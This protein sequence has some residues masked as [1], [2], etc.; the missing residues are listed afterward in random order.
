MR[1][2]RKIVLSI[3]NV[4]STHHVDPK[5]WKPSRPRGV[6][7]VIGI[8]YRRQRFC[9]PSLLLRVIGFHCSQRPIADVASKFSLSIDCLDAKSPICASWRW[10]INSWPRSYLR[11]SF[12]IL[13]PARKV[14]HIMNYPLG[15][16]LYARTIIIHKSL[17]VR[18]QLQELWSFLGQ[19]LN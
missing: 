1:A 14:T 10:E 9:G 16:V 13:S 3:S 4:N 8:G 18:S 6:S 11:Y 19:F 7:W 12:Q 2:I 5:R 15:I 17:Y